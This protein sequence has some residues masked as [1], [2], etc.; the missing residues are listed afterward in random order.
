MALKARSGASC[1]AWSPRIATMRFRRR[2]WRT[3]KGES[4]AKAINAFA[5]RLAPASRARKDAWGA[6]ISPGGGG[7]ERCGATERRTCMPTPAESS[8]FERKNISRG[9]REHATPEN[10][11]HPTH[12]APMGE[13][14]GTI[15]TSAQGPKQASGDSHLDAA[16][17][18]GSSRSRRPSSS[19]SE[20]AAEKGLGLRQ[21][22]LSCAGD[23]GGRAEKNAAGAARAT[24]A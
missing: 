24:D 13:L 1:G 22:K 10:W 11:A 9:R 16:A 20:Q 5:H 8:S 2:G 15:K 12:A 23:S 21:V 19:S 18:A 4:A 14:T 7:A 17:P 3:W 6:P